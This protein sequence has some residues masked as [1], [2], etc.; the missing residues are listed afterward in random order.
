[1]STTAKAVLRQNQLLRGLAEDTLDRI[2]AL[3]VRRNYPRGTAVFREGDPGD[4][5]YV[6]I[7]GQVRISTTHAD[8]REVFLSLMEQGDSFGEIAVV[9]GRDRTATATAV[10]DSSLFLIGRADLFA[11]MERDP[12]LP[13]YLLGVFCRRIRWTSDLVEEA[14][15]LDVPARLAR[16]LLRLA[17]DH[18]TS[19]PGG[20]A[21]KLSQADLAS[22]LG[23]SRQVVN[24]HLQGWRERGWIALSRGQ[25][26]IRDRE[27]LDTQSGRSTDATET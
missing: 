27:A 5:L 9:D 20:T 8:G 10:V 13:I 21:L 1:M 16:R 12:R 17:A 15:F 14:V 11:L 24:Q 19:V 22:F 25:V 2:A 6:V 3:A 26:V 7:T 23:A 18:G 4:S